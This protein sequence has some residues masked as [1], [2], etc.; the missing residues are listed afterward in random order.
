MGRHGQAARAPEPAGVAWLTVS[1]TRDELSDRSGPLARQR[2]E[3]AGHRV[4]DSRIVADEPETVREV[5]RAWLARADVQAI[6]TSGGT[7]IAP[8]DRT[9]EALAAL[10][11]IRLD[12]FGEL[13]RMLSWE[14]VGSAAM[15]SRAV[16]GVARGRL[17]FC[18]PGSPAAVELALDR[19]V[20]PELAHLLSELR[21]P[22]R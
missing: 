17:L 6:V 21:R 9:Y 8:R 1:D 5:V 2:I 10:L 16:G 15:A 7:G 13:F 18:L 20:L 11:E 12:G 22:A 19:L 3:A 4:V 14:Q